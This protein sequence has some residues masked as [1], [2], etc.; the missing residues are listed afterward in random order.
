LRPFLRL[1]AALCYYT[2][3][4]MLL[5]HCSRSLHC[6]LLPRDLLMLHS[7]LHCFWIWHFTLGSHQGDWLRVCQRESSREHLVTMGSI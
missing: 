7:G 1:T 3:L 5:L 2:L 4:P 6:G